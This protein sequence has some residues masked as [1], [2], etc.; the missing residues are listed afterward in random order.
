MAYYRGYRGKKKTTQFNGPTKAA[1]LKSPK[2]G[3]LKVISPYSADF[4]DELKSTIQP[5]HRHWNPDEKYWL[6]NEIYLE[7]LVTI[8]KRH[9][10][11]VTTDLLGEESQ[12]SNLFS[13]IFEILPKEYVDKVYFILASAIHPDHGGNEALIKQLNEAYQEKK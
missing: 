2:E 12:P 1:I 3:W 4:V 7:D 10:N 11:E 6:I 5:S 13:Q 9:Y 8:L